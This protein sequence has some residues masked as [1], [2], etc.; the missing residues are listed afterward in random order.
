MKRL[1]AWRR[2]LP[3]KPAVAHLVEKFSTVISLPSLRLT[4]INPTTIGLGYSIN[5][6]H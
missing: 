2:D 5:M 3:E 4:D 1:E 6:S